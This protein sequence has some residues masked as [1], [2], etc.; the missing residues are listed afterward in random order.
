MD[1]LDEIHPKVSLS[2]CL[3]MPVGTKM[4]NACIHILRD[5]SHNLIY[6]VFLVESTSVYILQ[7]HCLSTDNLFFFLRINILVHKCP[8]I[9][10]TRIYLFVSCL[11]SRTSE[12]EIQIML[13]ALSFFFF[14]FQINFPIE[15]DRHR[16]SRKL[17]FSMFID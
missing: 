6:F 14:F 12:F 8:L 9:I 2:T 5:V 10:F 7:V 17:V 11:L 15:V 16:L 13:H 3:A 4:Q 1:E